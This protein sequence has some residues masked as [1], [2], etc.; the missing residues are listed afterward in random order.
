MGNKIMRILFTTL[1]MLSTT[2]CTKVPEKP[3]TPY[4]T[5]TSVTSIIEVEESVSSFSMLETQPTGV[6]TALLVEESEATTTEIET[7]VATENTCTTTFVETTFVETSEKTN[8]PSNVETETTAV[9]TEAETTQSEETEEVVTTKVEKEKS[10]TKQTVKEGKRVVLDVIN[11]QQLPELPAGCEITSTTIVLNYEGIEVD[12]MTLLDYLPRV[13]YPVEGERWDSPWEKFIGDPTS[14]RYGCY[15][16]VII[17]TVNAF[18]ESNDI[19]SYEV[20]DISGSSI[21]ELYAQIDKGHPVIVWATAFMKKSWLGPSWELKDGST[22]RWR[23]K[24]HCLVL[25]GYD[26]GA[27]TVILSDPF[28]ERGTVEYDASLF[29]K[30]YKELYE[31]ALVIQKNAE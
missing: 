19:T 31:Q 16:P 8:L 4:V 13:G 7:S 1:V 29:E 10:D 17:K 18:F 25:I 2:C 9:T 6:T 22:F 12:K 20:I 3:L 26:T 24:E 28:D 23:V 14:D 27:D 30:R 15:S 21:K 5:T 11:I